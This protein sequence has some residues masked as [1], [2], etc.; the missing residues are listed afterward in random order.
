MTEF[1]TNATKVFFGISIRPLK[2]GQLLIRLYYHKETSYASAEEHVRYLWSDLAMAKLRNLSIVHE[3]CTAPM[4]TPPHSYQ[5]DAKLCL[6]LGIF[7]NYHVLAKKVFYDLN[8]TYVFEHGIPN[9]IWMADHV[10]PQNSR[11]FQY[12]NVFHSLLQ[13]DQ[14]ESWRAPVYH[15]LLWILQNTDS[16]CYAINFTI[17]DDHSVRIRVH[18]TKHATLAYL[19]ALQAYYEIE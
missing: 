10:P 19:D 1:W 13:R 5:Q 2:H 14:V 18:C 3:P 12:V 6:R 15:I 8:M 17:L 4:P 16:T 9:G 7:P 11:Q